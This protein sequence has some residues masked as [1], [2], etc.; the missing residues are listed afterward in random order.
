ME[1]NK[2][3]QKITCMVVVCAFPLLA[4]TQNII[5]LNFDNPIPFAANAGDDKIITIGENVTLGAIETAVGNLGQVTYVWSPSDGLS[6]TTVANPTASP[7]ATT[8]YTVKVIDENGCLVTDEVMV[9]VNAIS[10][11]KDMTDN[12]KN[13]IILYPNPNKGT[14]VVRP[15]LSLIPIQSNISIID[16]TGKTVYFEKIQEL[17]NEYQINVSFLQKGV[18][19]VKL[20]NGWKQEFVK[21]TIN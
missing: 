5:T 8:V 14:F 9:T 13:P 20:S 10:G 11:V 1:E 3:L 16:I 7:S 12:N 17:R 6:N 2:F 18:Y 21:F 19:T 4:M 15:G